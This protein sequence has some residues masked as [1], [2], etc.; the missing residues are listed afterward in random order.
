MDAS[1]DIA[2]RVT[3]LRKSAV[4][5]RSAL[6]LAEVAREPGLPLAELA[7]AVGLLAQLGAACEADF[8]SLLSLE[9]AIL[10]RPDPH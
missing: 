3:L 2:A 8:G 6:E 5:R 4:R 1:D 9:I 7:A 10:G